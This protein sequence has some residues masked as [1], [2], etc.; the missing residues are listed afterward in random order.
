MAPGCIPPARDT[1][2][3][4]CASVFLVFFRTWELDLLGMSTF[5]LRRLQYSSLLMWPPPVCLC[6]N[7]FMRAPFPFRRVPPDSYVSFAQA[8]MGFSMFFA[9]LCNVRAWIVLNKGLPTSWIK[10]TRLGSVLYRSSKV[11][12]ENRYH[13]TPLLCPSPP[14]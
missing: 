7:G 9:P 3:P 1:P 5:T 8:Q 13:L 2:G 4:V 10:I 14:V 11:A 6:E 12:M